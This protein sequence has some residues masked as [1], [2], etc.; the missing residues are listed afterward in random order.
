MSFYH[1]TPFGILTFIVT[2]LMQL[3]YEFALLSCVTINVHCR[4]LNVDGVSSVHHFKT[5]ETFACWTIGNTI[6]A[7][8]LH[9]M[10]I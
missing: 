7:F 6:A 3:E 8:A 1:Y 2:L 10:L 9:W 4:M 5:I